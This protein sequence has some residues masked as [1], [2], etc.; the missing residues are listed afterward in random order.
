MLNCRFKR[1]LTA[2]RVPLYRRTRKGGVRGTFTTLK[3][4]IYRSTGC[5]Q[6]PGSGD[7]NITFGSQYTDTENAI[8]FEGR[9]NVN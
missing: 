8:I 6:A 9:Y 5:V 1:D 3:S 7:T 4:R 2:V